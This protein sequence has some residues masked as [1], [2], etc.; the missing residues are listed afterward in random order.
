MASPPI[1]DLDA[2]LAPIPGANPAGE[3]LSFLV[4]K[5]LDDS[6]KEILPSQ[7]AANDPRRPE[8][9]QPADWHGIQQLASDTLAKTSKD[10]LV[11]ARLTE[12]MVKQHGFHGLRDGLRLL[13]RLVEECWDRVYPAIQDGDLEV[14]AGPFDWLDDDRR[15]SLF[16]ITVR[17]APLTKVGDESKFGWQHWKDAQDSRGSVS[18]DAFDAAVAATPREFCQGV[19]DDIAEC[20]DEL[21]KLTGALSTRM[22]EAAPALSLV[23]RAV[24]ECQTL[25]Q[26]ILKRKGPPLVVAPPEAA[27]PA[28][29]GADGAPA[30]AGAEANSA[31]RAGPRPLT[32][33]DLLNRLA[34]ASAQLLQ[35]EPHSP[36]AYMIQRAVK[37]AR[38]PFPDL[39][40]VLVRDA[41]VLGQLD[42]DLDLGIE[43]EK[44]DQAKPAKGK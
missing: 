26:Q 5:K 6:R 2:L 8:V 33:D 44:Q 20:V 34:D 35:M 27:L 22:G 16:P 1:L 13:R 43:K 12:A 37:L 42:R 15:G 7:F 25:A 31:P 10:L 3:P 18:A 38:L 24:L 17:M 41:G 39:M 14:R 9:A 11:A 28:E 36:I 21:T 29:A 40:K 32:R 19:V 23:G 30:A 4:R